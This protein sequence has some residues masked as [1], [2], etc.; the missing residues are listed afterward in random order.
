MNKSLRYVLAAFI[1]VLLLAG[2]FS[3]GLVVGWLLPSRALA[4]APLALPGRAAAPSG[5]AST[6]SQNSATPQDLQDL[7]KPF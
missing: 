2:T 6:D 3:G 4:S 7:F 1:A 5:A